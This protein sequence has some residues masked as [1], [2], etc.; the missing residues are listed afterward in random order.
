[1]LPSEKVL[2]VK[3]LVKAALDVRDSIN[4]PGSDSWLTRTPKKRTL[5]GKIECQYRVLM[6]LGLDALFPF[7]EDFILCI[8]V[9]LRKCSTIERIRIKE[10]D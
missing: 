8:W 10:R 6:G 3:M 2:N 1:M 9:D 7:S 4:V 5:L